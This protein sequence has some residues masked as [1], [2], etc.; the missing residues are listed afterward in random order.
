MTLEEL[1]KIAG[2]ATLGT[3]CYSLPET[4]RALVKVALAAK[5]KRAAKNWG[6]RGADHAMTAALRDLDAAMVGVR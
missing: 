2:E 3:Y 1:G 4:L 6:Q 5:A